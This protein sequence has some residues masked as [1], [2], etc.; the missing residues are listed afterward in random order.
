MS[1]QFTLQER[2]VYISRN[3]L[4]NIAM[5]EKQQKPEVDVL[6]KKINEMLRS[7]GLAPMKTETKTGSFIYIPRKKPNDPAE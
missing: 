7:H 3:T 2:L 6:A 4:K 5:E 1:L